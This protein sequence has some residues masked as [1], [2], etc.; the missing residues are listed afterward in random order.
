MAELNWTAYR[1]NVPPGAK[2]LC[3]PS[4]AVAPA[5]PKKVRESLATIFGR[6]RERPGVWAKIGVYKNAATVDMTV[7]NVRRRLGARKMGEY[8]VAVLPES[9]GPGRG[10]KGDGVILL[11]RY[12]G[13]LAKEGSGGGGT[14]PA[15][16][17]VLAPGAFPEWPSGR[18]S[19]ATSGQVDIATLPCAVA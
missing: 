16:T 13:K 12:V 3:G 17:A 11:A 14:P 10:K 9:S 7:Y 8:D 1:S 4:K 6:L 5:K 18:G 15:E 19:A 2:I